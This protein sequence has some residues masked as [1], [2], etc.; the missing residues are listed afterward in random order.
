MPY[1]TYSLDLAMCDFYLFGC[2]KELSKGVTAMDADNL[3]NEVMK[4]LQKHF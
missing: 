1:P 4:I 2:I 3:R